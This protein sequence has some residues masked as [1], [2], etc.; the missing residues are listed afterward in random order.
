MELL[1]LIVLVTSVALVARK[2]TS[3]A[4]S[5]THQTRTQKKV[6]REE[7]P[8]DDW[9]VNETSSPNRRFTVGWRSGHQQGTTWEFGRVVLR[10]SNKGIVFSVALE[11]PNAAYVDDA[12][13]VVVEDWLREDLSGAIHRFNSNGELLW[14][15]RY[16]ANIG[17]SGISCSGKLVFVTT[18]RS[19]SETHSQKV[20]LLDGDTG[21]PLWVHD[22][23]E[24]VR[25]KGEKLVRILELP[26]GS[27]KT[28]AFD[29]NGNLP[30]DLFEAQAV[31]FKERDRRKHWVAL[32][33]AQEA[34]RSGNLAG[35]ESELALLKEQ[36]SE[37]PPKV[38]ALYWR[39]CGEIS[40]LRGDKEGT[41]RDWEKALSLDPKVGIRRRLDQL[42]SQTTGD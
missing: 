27:K 1:L 37:L 12:G 3:G 7:P 6:R 40:L 13:N 32:P 36:L 9:M 5:V 24:D 8:L 31:A 4:S 17:E 20:F 39:T 38:Q 15:T 41:L 42:R 26:D 30:D 16:C 21:K 35:A 11:R 25:F 18:L 34:L 29:S 19:D 33:A 2:L 28:F 10:E 14:T 23:W 22:G